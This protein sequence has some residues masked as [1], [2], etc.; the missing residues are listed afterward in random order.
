MM[1]F[2]KKAVALSL[3][4]T[5]ALAFL[6]SCS[7]DYGKAK[8]KADEA[9]TKQAYTVD[10]EL[11]FECDDDTVSGVFE[12]LENASTKLYFKDGYFKAEDTLIISYENNGQAVTTAFKMTYTSLAGII[13]SNMIYTSGG[14]QQRDVK[15]KAVINDELLGAFAGRLAFIGELSGEYFGEATK[16]KRG[17][18]SFIVYSGANDGARVI[19]EE[20]MAKKLEGSSDSVELK[21]ARLT[22][23]IEDGKYD[24]VTVE[25]EYEITMQ[26]KAYPVGAEI[27]LDFG[28]GESFD[29]SVPAD[30]DSY[31]STELE[32]I[33]G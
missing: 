29:I 33:I 2:I 24:T 27:E 26:G 3:V 23:E 22:I 4:L 17:G 28:Y 15:S 20:A 5:M 19:L 25:C 14:T 6:T 30:A 32:N 11:D 8:K 1:Q 18:E 12:Q 7:R 9:L 31:G 16:G 21:D 13:Y 10:V